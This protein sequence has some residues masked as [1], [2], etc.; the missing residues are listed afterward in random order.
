M[1]SRTVLCGSIRLS[2]AAFT[3]AQDIPLMEMTF[4]ASDDP[5]ETG[6][7]MKGVKTKDLFAA[8]GEFRRW[9][10]NSYDPKGKHWVFGVSLHDDELPNANT[11]GLPKNLSAL[12]DEPGTDFVVALAEWSGQ[13]EMAWRVEKGNGT[14]VTDLPKLPE[15]LAALIAEGKYDE[16][17]GKVSAL[18]LK[19]CGGQ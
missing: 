2:K 1:G 19:A 9:A 18:L 8:A 13:L 17:M 12:K 5:D 3:T 11:D 6:V 15:S 10:K 7:I 14:E 4:M 16:A